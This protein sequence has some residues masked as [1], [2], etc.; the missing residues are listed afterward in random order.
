M[1][2]QQLEIL[3]DKQSVSCVGYNYVNQPATRDHGRLQQQA[4]SLFGRVSTTSSWIYDYPSNSDLF[5]ETAQRTTFD[6]YTL[7]DETNYSLSSGLTITHKDQTCAQTCFQYDKLGCLVKSTVSPDTPYEA[8]R[9]HEYAF[10]KETAG[11]SLTVTDAKQ[12][13]GYDRSHLR[14]GER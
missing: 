7:Q 2:A 14:S 5:T 10:L 1:A 8:A 3:Q 13:Q 11:C 6:G 4:T 9:R 12:V